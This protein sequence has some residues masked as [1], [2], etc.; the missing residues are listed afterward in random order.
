MHNSLLIFKNCSLR[1]L[2]TDDSRT[3]DI[4]SYDCSYSI[5]TILSHLDKYKDLCIIEMAITDSQ[6]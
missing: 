6:L 5:I 1:I 2:L 4:A 3:A